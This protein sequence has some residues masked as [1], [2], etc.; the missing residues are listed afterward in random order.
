[1]VKLGKVYYKEVTALPNE[2]KD[3]FKNLKK[4]LANYTYFSKG[5][6]TV[7][8]DNKKLQFI[9][10]RFNLNEDIIDN[11]IELAMKKSNFTMDYD[12]AG[13]K[14]SKSI[15]LANQTKGIL[16]EIGAQLILEEILKFKSV[17]RW[18]L[19]RETFKYL[20][21]EYD[22]KFEHNKK[23]YLCESRSSTSYK[24]SLGEFIER[25]HIIGPYTSKQKHSEDNND[26]Y[27]RPVFQYNNYNKTWSTLPY[28]KKTSVLEDLD[29]GELQLYFVS[30]ATLDE[31]YSENSE[32]GNN[33]QQGTQYRQIRMIYTG[34]VEVFL[35]NI[36]NTANA[37]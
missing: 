27:F 13:N 33:A 24:T 29:S 12:Q 37:I 18:D 8:V 34:D 16:A 30:G 11:A 1:M 21:A 9:V 3:K 31:M 22:V 19:E 7:N 4:R 14:R 25:Y 20:P 17:K 35:K 26:F 32:V 23:E 5:S 2:F 28:E 36:I 10:Y 6:V 15:K